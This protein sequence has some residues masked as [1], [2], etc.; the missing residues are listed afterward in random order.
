MIGFS[1]RTYARILLPADSASKDTVRFPL[2]TE[3]NNPYEKGNQGNLYLG[4]PS[5]IKKDIEYNPE[6][7]E[8]EFKQSIGEGI[9]VTPPVSMGLDEYINYNLE[10]SKNDYWREKAAEQGLGQRKSNKPELDLKSEAVDRIFGGSEVDIRPNGQAQL[11]FGINRYKTENPI[12]PVRN[13]ATTTF[14]FDMK[15]QLNVIGKIGDKLKLTTNYNT[16]S[17]FDF[18]NQ[19]KLEYTGYEDE[20]IKKIEAGNVSFPLRSSLITGSQS[21]FGVKTELQFGRLYVTSVLSQQKGRRSEIEVQGGAQINEFEVKADEYE[22]NKH[23]FLAHHFR[24]TYEESVS[25]PPTI[26]APV[27]ITRIEV[28]VTNTNTTTDDTRNIICFQDLGENDAEHFYNP[29]FVQEMPGF[30]YPDN[31]ANNIYDKMN[32]NTNVRSFIYSTGELNDMGLIGKLDYQRVELA[33]MLNENEYTVHPQLGYIS[34]R[35]ELNTNQALAV[36]Y[37]YTYQGEV[38]KVGEFSNE[39]EGQKA[40]ILKMLKSTQRN[41][42]IPMWDLMMKNIYPLGAYNIQKDGFQLEVWYLNASTGIDNNYIP[43]PNKNGGN[44]N[45]QLIKVLNLDKLDVNQNRRSDGVFDYLEGFNIISSNGRLIFPVLEP[46]GSHIRNRFG[47]DYQHLADNYAFDSL[48]T[49]TKANAKVKF[50]EK[51][52]FTIKGQSKSSSGS[53]ISLGALNVPEGSVVVTHGGVP[54]TE[55][56]DYLVDYQIGRVTIINQSIM[57]SG[58]PIKVSLE[59]Q[60]MF[61]IQNKTLFASRFDYTLS[62]DIILGG[63]IMRLSERPIT[64]KTNYGDEPIAN[65]MVGLDGSFKK[66]SPFLTA[67]VDKIPLIETKA[68][69][70]ISV[71]AE[72]AKLFPGHSRALSKEGVSYVDDFEGSQTSINLS[73]GAITQWVLAS[74]PQGQPDLFPE[75]SLVNDLGFGYNRAKLS[76]YVLDNIFWQTDN[77][78]PEHIKNDLDM[79]SNHFMRVVWQDEVFPNKSLS[80]TAQNNVSMFDLAFRPNERGPYN[81]DVDGFTPNGARYGF[82]M[83]EDG[84]L[85]SPESR[86]GGIMRKMETNDFD[87]ANIQFI[88]FW[89]MDPFA[90]S[91]DPNFPGDETNGQLYFN[92]GEISEDLLRDGQKSFEQGL[93]STAAEATDL[94]DPSVFTSWGRIPPLG[95]QAIV[96][97][98]DNDPET[99]EFQDVGMEGLRDEEERLFFEDVF[100][101][102]IEQLYGESSVA[103]QLASNDPSA[104]N[105]HHFRGDD[106]DRNQIDILERYKN[107]NGMDGNSPT[108][109]QDKAKNS[110]GYPTSQTSRPNEEDINSDNTLDDVESYF[111]YRVNINTKDISP[112]NVGNNYITN[113]LETRASTENGLNRPIKWYQFKIPIEDFERAVGGISDFRAIRFMRIYVKGFKKPVF[114]RF[115]QLE[116]V[117]GEWRKYTKNIDDPGLYPNEEAASTFNIG[118]LNIEENS[119][120]TPVNYV[121]PPELSREVNATSTNYAL[122][123]EQSMSLEICDLE[124]GQ[125]RAAYKSVDLD[126]RSYKKLKMYV[127]AEARNN[128]SLENNDLVAF[129]RLG[130][131]FENNYYEY[132]IPLKVTPPGVYGA[133]SESEREKVWPEANNMEIVFEDLYSLKVERNR[134]ILNNADGVSNQVPYEGS[135]GKAGISVIGNPTL[136]NIKTIMIGV[137]NPK[138]DGIPKCAE[139]WVNELRLSDF[140]KNGGW[141]AVGRATAQLADFANVAVSGS[142]STPGFGSIEQRVS[143]RQR[144]TVQSVDVSTTVQLGKF[145]PEEAGLRLPMYVGYSKGQIIPQFAP[146][147]DDVPTKVYEDLMKEESDINIDS[148]KAVTRDITTR[149]S[150]NFTNIRKEKSKNK[151]DAKPHFYDVSNWTGSY[152]YTEQNHHNFDLVEDKLVNHKGGLSY[153]FNANPKPIEP[154]KKSKALKSKYLKPIKDINFYLAP[155]QI[156]FRTD[157]NR[158]YN[159]RQLRNNIPGALDPDPFYNKSFTWGRMY[160]FKYDLTKALKL[161]F[162]AATNSLIREPDGVVHRDS[163]NYS[164]WTEDVKAEVLNLGTT[165]D[166]RQNTS[167]NYTLPF[168]QIPLT[169]WINSTV[170]YTAS[171]NWKRASFAAENWGHTIQNSQNIN[172]NNTFNMLTLYNKVG[173]LKK[174]N[175]KFRRRSRP[176]SRKEGEKKKKDKNS[177][178]VPDRIAKLLMSVKNVNASISQ[179]RGIL[180]PGYVNDTTANRQIYFFGMDQKF[181]APGAGFIF[182]QQTGWGGNDTLTY[183]EYAAQNGW[184]QR[185]STINSPFSQ[186]YSF[187]LNL[188]ATLEPVQDMRIELTSTYKH[189][190]NYS[191]YHRYQGDE[192]SLNSDFGIWQTESPLESGNFSA[193]IIS[194]KTAFNDDPNADQSATFEKFIEN[195]KIISERLAA[196]ANVTNVNDS[197][198]YMDGYSGTA[199]QVLIPAFLATYTGAD[200][201][202]VSLDPMNV[203]YKG[204]SYLPLPNWRVRYTGLSKVPALQNLFRSVTLNHQYQSTY[205][206]GSFTSNIDYVPNDPVNEEFSVYKDPL[207]GNYL[208]KYQ[209]NTITISEQFSPLINID[210]TWKNSLLTRFEIK[211]DRNL[212]FSLTNTQ[213]TEVIGQEYVVGIGYTVQSVK[214]PF[215]LRAGTPVQSDLKLRLDFSYRKNQTAI[216]KVV[217]RTNQKSA[218]SNIIAVKVTADY[219]LSDK[220]NIRGF[221]QFNKNIPVISTTFPRSD[222][223]AGITLMFTLSP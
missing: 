82:G 52:R 222:T 88:Q 81:Y 126:V 41:T 93:P 60:D 174:V 13:Q 221:Y 48:Y 65:T 169:N 165:T 127:H 70:T 159:Q 40:L 220:L 138:N 200:P 198:G 3:S 21:L 5:N 68:K 104:D 199:P 91:D 69:S 38:Y 209:M 98:F 8:Y 76:W 74:T 61:G 106:Y 185:D 152:A 223:N 216:R 71:D 75:G 213:L 15:I 140:D 103:Y 146:Q 124:D 78:T 85:K 148:L 108:S 18:Q 180:L 107:Y 96:H 110:E 192:A 123:N 205:N 147:A 191:E 143:E 145:L 47:E 182:G 1:G 210:M 188:R 19:M 28:W 184:L 31:Y 17:T 156:G 132:A 43:L 64:F 162:N 97:A 37:Q 23:F 94:S 14:D 89:L 121:L 193:T 99:R 109:E 36:A 25:K 135:S 114:L 11:T 112:E 179:T 54:L 86:W 207:S 119:S 157:V 33:R 7:G 153:N 117:R 170:R 111:Q 151:S 84:T 161:D 122:L 202:D 168:R 128:Q 34:L 51:N 218:G 129:I 24:D 219:K 217:E 150:I 83:N 189:G 155:K 42:K 163:S 77:S 35:Q 136:S 141:A 203:G 201:N 158:M 120:K 176:S 29:G 9:E 187:N 59:S 118:A 215:Q 92:L 181:D 194:I 105:Y 45:T 50:P 4:Q 177:I 58:S 73:G 133:S 144:E 142:I 125:S 30:N 183:A 149:K 206:I 80:N 16:E 139:V 63:T 212:S 173:Y 130:S 87:A 95:T 175:N 154:F 26:T 10:N 32:G 137:K 20:I 6:T 12:I 134:Q 211:R 186:T 204:I 49:T 57:E 166:Y 53:E 113:V 62:E 116:L 22:Q 44:T 100:L 2:K 46:F 39:V 160:D 197:T 55:N 66:E 131:D 171:Y 208:P 102:K 195:R 178:T 167:L 214:M 172:L 27:N 67:M 115:A 90:E 101:D 72:V 196:R 190:I 79:R 164:E 56:V